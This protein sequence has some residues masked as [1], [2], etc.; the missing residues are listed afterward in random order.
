MISI[1]RYVGERGLLLRKIDQAVDDSIEELTERTAEVELS[2]VVRACLLL[3][4]P[5]GC[6]EGFDGGPTSLESVGLL[7]T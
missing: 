6:D 4:S 7:S 1:S 2:A 3:E 5:P